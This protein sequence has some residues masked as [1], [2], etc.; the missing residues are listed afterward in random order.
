MQEDTASATR[1]EHQDSESA[2]DCI[3][4]RFVDDAVLSALSIVNMDLQQDYRQAVLLGCG[5]DTRPFRSVHHTVCLDQCNNRVKD[6]FL[7]EGSAPKL[8][9]AHHDV[10]LTHQLGFLGFLV[11]ICAGCCG[12]W[13]VSCVKQSG[14]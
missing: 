9:L 6:Q 5:M 4:T 10:C 13:A 2:A 1:Q 7:V 8:L 14:A 3:A 12:Q 11:W